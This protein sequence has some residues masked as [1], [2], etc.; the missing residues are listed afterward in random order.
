MAGPQL[1]KCY[2]IFHCVCDD[3]CKLHLWRLR[4]YVQENVLVFVCMDF[5]SATMGRGTRLEK[6]THHFIIVVMK[7]Q[8][9]V[10]ACTSIILVPLH[11]SS[12]ERSTRL[13]NISLLNQEIC[14]HPPAYRHMCSD[15]DQHLCIRISIQPWVL[16]H[17]SGTTYNMHVSCI[18]PYDAPRL[19]LDSLHAINNSLSKPCM[20]KRNH[21]NYKGNRDH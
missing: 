1:A 13:I 18:R 6:G 12:H 10:H 7:K 5:G 2:R 11:Y 17:Q 19:H 4:W 21:D 15:T 16:G 20:K 9:Y 14:Y 3:T 8:Y